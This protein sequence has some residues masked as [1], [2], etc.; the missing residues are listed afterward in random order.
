[1]NEADFQNAQL[2][3]VKYKN[4]QLEKNDFT[5]AKLKTVDLRSSQLFNI[6]GWTSMKGAI[7]DHGQ[8][9]SITPELAMQLEIDVKD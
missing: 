7:L 5:L 9:M 6:R 8:L 1:M 3:E 4:C 2:T